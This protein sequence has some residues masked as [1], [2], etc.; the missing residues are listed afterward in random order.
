[1][2]KQVQL[3][4]QNWQSV[5]SLFHDLE[6]KLKDVP[7]P[8]LEGLKKHLNSLTVNWKSCVTTE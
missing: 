3:Y 4:E 6:M 7:K 8:D 5:I 1:M 2:E